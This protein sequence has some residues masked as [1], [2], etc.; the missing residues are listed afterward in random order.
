M[1]LLP[2]DQFYLQRSDGGTKK[3]DKMKVSLTELEDHILGGYVDG[4]DEVKDLL[5][6]ETDA[7]IEGDENLKGQVDGLTDRMRVISNELYD[8]VVQNE[9]EHKFD[10]LQFENYKIQI[11][12]DC[13]TSQPDFEQALCR[14]GKLD[15]FCQ[16]VATDPLADSRGGFYL[17]SLGYNY[18]QTEGILISDT[19]KAGGRVDLSQVTLG[20]LIEVINIIQTDA[21]TDGIDN[22]NYGFYKITSIGAVEEESN[23]KDGDGGSSYLHAF[24]VSYVGSSGKASTQPTEN[25]FLLKIVLDLVSTLNDVYVNKLGDDMTGTLNID[26][27]NNVAP[28]DPLNQV[29]LHTSNNMEAAAL[30]LTG[31]SAESSNN[32]IS[33]HI[34]NNKSTEI[35]FDTFENTRFYFNGNWKIVDN[36]RVQDKEDAIISFYQF[37]DVDGDL[38]AQPSRLVVTPR[39]RLQTPCSYIFGLDLNSP[40]NAGDQNI[41]PP[42]SYVDQMDGI[43]ENQINDVSQR[44]DTLARASEIYQYRLLL[45]SDVQACTND[46]NSGLMDEYNPDNL[47]GERYPHYDP[48]DPAAYNPDDVSNAV[49][50]AD[51][52]K[53]QIVN[54][55]DL[56]AVRGKFDMRTFVEQYINPNSGLE[57]VRDTDYLVIDNV[58]NLLDENSTP[59]TIDWANSLEV[60]DYLEV[61]PSDGRTAAYVMYVVEN[62]D[63]STTS[64][65][66]VKTQILY[67]AGVEFLDGQN[68]KIKFYKK[69]G[70][71]EMT[72]LYPIFVNK[73]GDSVFGTLEWQLTPTESQ[74]PIKYVDALSKQEYFTV[75]NYGAITGKNLTLN[76]ND[77]ENPKFV[78]KDRTIWADCG[79]TALTITNKAVQNFLFTSDVS[80][81]ALSITPTVVDVFDKRIENVADPSK[82]QDAVTLSYLLGRSEGTAAFLRS[83]DK[84]IS[85]EQDATGGN[86]LNLEVGV[87]PLTR[88]SDVTIDIDKL[89]DKRAILYNGTNRQWEVSEDQIKSFTPGNKVAYN[90]NDSINNVE[91]GGLYMNPQNGTLSLRIQ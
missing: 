78:I 28:Y 60:G 32:P 53:Y 5:Q 19:T 23:G 12:T 6:E 86:S 51:C 81:D 52:I 47:S 35:K 46:L 57:E 68:Y 87:L 39:V 85:I 56:G 65:A 73:V 18:E 70:G 9:Y 64:I 31:Y 42:R 80:G 29:G 89:Q 33:L 24:G 37:V 72:D 4:I 50:W 15:A 63:I 84:S 34:K 79:Q 74:G 16:G 36:D 48:L 55:P 44:I 17:A 49:L 21:G 66:I 54:N 88:L 11:L 40:D 69:A 67:K 75:D 62:I 25:R 26:L 59:V 27:L 76:D 22:Y 7:R 3:Y 2:Y 41:L 90:G 1:S 77:V 58:T 71:L 45:P 38:G 30:T 20:S 83:L 91:V 13:S 8:T 61:T 10:Y 14:A 82:N 43:L